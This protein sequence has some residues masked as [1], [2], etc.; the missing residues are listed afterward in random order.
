MP[1]PAAPIRA[2]PQKREGT[3]QGPPSLRGPSATGD[4]MAAIYAMEEPGSHPNHEDLTGIPPEYHSLFKP[5]LDKRDLQLSRIKDAWITGEI[6][7]SDKTTLNEIIDEE[8]EIKHWMKEAQQGIDP[9]KI[10]SEMRGEKAQYQT[11]KPKEQPAPPIKTPHKE[12]VLSQAR[13]LLDQAKKARREGD[14]ETEDELKKKIT[15]EVTR[16]AASGVKV[17]LSDLAK[18]PGETL[19]EKVAS[20]IS[21]D[22]GDDGDDDL[23]I[24]GQTSRTPEK[25]HVH[26]P[27]TQHQ[28]TYKEQDHRSPPPKFQ[29]TPPGQFRPSTSLEYQTPPITKSESTRPETTK[30]KSA[31]PP[32]NALQIARTIWRINM[33][34]DNKIHSKGGD[35][36]R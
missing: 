1:P 16:L 7:E 17:N 19:H 11:G 14:L 29:S 3:T 33:A 20:K 6:G 27:P 26:D 8:K 25:E 9:Q 35:R 30:R 13:N 34:V 4:I 18:P 22:G 31:M 23:G 5:L 32:T 36:L 24:D 15:K 21:G 2:P 10:L 12:D 28:P